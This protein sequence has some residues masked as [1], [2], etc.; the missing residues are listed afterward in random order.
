MNNMIW[1]T[2][3]RAGVIRILGSNVDLFPK[4]PMLAVGFMVAEMAFSALIK[5][6]VG[7]YE[8]EYDTSIGAYRFRDTVCGPWCQWRS[9]EGA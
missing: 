9:C 2:I 7:R 1:K 5:F 4:I 3:S 8:W 6:Q